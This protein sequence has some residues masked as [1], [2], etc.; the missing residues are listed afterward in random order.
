MSIVNYISRIRA[1]VAN[2]ICTIY[3]TS[4]LLLISNHIQSKIIYRTK[5]S[6]KL[7]CCNSDNQCLRNDF[8]L[9]IKEKVEY[10]GDTLGANAIWINSIYQSGGLYDGND[11]TDHKKVD[12]VLGTME[13]FD[14]LRKDTKKKGLHKYI[15]HSNKLHGTQFPCSFLIFFKHLCEVSFFVY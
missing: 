8:F 12:I 7:V 11:V 9:G 1:F 5:S 14:S 4:S 2:F 6:Y 3:Y 10:I 13:D 15:V